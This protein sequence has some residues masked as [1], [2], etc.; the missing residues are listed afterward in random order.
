[1]GNMRFSKLSLLMINIVVIILVAKAKPVFSETIM[2]EKDETFEK[3]TRLVED[4]IKELKNAETLAIDQKSSGIQKIN[5]I[6]TI[7]L[8]VHADPELTEKIKN[9]SEE[10]SNGESSSDD[11]RHKVIN[12]FMK[13]VGQEAPL[14]NQLLTQWL[15]PGLLFFGDDARTFQGEMSQA[16]AESTKRYSHLDWQKLSKVSK[17][18]AT[19][20][21]VCDWQRDLRKR[22]KQ[23]LKRINQTTSTPHSRETST[24]SF[25]NQETATIFMLTYLYRSDLRFLGKI[26]DLLEGWLKSPEN[27]ETVSV[28]MLDEL[29]DLAK[30][31]F[32]L[33]NCAPA[34]MFRDPLAYRYDDETTICQMDINLDWV[35]FNRMLNNLTE[36]NLAFRRFRKGNRETPAPTLDSQVTGHEAVQSE[37]SRT[38]NDFFYGVAPKL[39]EDFQG[40]KGE[41][42]NIES[43]EMN[44]LRSELSL[45]FDEFHKL[46]KNYDQGDEE[47]GKVL[48]FFT[49]DLESVLEIMKQSVS[50]ESS[51][52]D[53][54]RSYFQVKFVSSY[55]QNMKTLFHSYRSFYF[56][57]LA[58]KAEHLAE[59]IDQFYRRWIEDLV[60]NKGARL[61]R[62]LKMDPKGNELK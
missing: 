56:S 30:R 22:Y 36:L 33:S 17:R 51:E 37:Y 11:L 34:I 50:E 62:S 4:R 35:C 59:L 13:Y 19:Y 2:D 40:I 15:E 28:E 32:N 43:T 39:A 31:D 44:E 58:G 45:R 21:A 42:L 52:W 10:L 14:Y 49:D 55:A 24:A 29:K 12:D 46:L 27:L 26:K 9:W 41:G 53:K 25:A 23:G 60:E 38:T 3:I 61:L 54:K 1:M 47:L 5:H 57:T 7:M 8:P 6:S 20:R 18:V 16:F 48:T